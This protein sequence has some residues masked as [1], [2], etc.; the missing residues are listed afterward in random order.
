MSTSSHNK[1]SWSTWYI[2]KRNLISK[3]ISF[4]LHQRPVTLNTMYNPKNNKQPWRTWDKF[5]E[6]KLILKSKNLW[7]ASKTSH[8]K[9]PCLPVATISEP[10]ALD[11]FQRDICFQNQNPLSYIKSNEWL[12]NW[13]FDSIS[14]FKA[15]Q[16]HQ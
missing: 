11:T 7:T 1:W 12:I 4:V 3:S 13:A 6:K 14:N 10:E 16:I 2:P 5:K 9:W 8:T 15:K